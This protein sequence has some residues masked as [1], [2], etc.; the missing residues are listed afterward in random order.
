MIQTTEENRR[1][2]RLASVNCND[3]PVRSNHSN[4]AGLIKEVRRNVQIAVCRTLGANESIKRVFVACYRPRNF[5]REAFDPPAVRRDYYVCGAR[6][7]ET[8]DPK[9]TTETL[10]RAEILITLILVCHLLP[11]VDAS[12][13]KS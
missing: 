12:C 3:T 13:S 7:N 4:S 9:V 2:M 8:Y 6:T 5:R 11:D 1:Q 10:V